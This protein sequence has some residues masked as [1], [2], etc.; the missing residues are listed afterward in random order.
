[1][2]NVTKTGAT[3][4]PKIKVEVVPKGEYKPGPKIKMPPG[5]T[6]IFAKHQALGGDTGLLGKATGPEQMTPNGQGWYRHY[7]H[8]SIYWTSAAGAFEVH[9]DIRAKWE[10][11]GWETSFL[12]FPITDETTTPDGVGR[13]NHFQG[14]SIYWTPATGAHEVHGDIR[15]KWSALGWERSY[16]GYPMSDEQTTPDGI[17]RYSDFEHGQITWSPALGA[18]VSFTSYD[19]AAGGGG[20]V[21]PQG[22][23][24]NGEPEVRRRLVCSAHMDLTDD[25]SWPWHDEHSSADGTNEAVLTTDLPQDV[26]TM[27]DGAGGELRV[28]LKLIAQVRSNGDVLVKG[29]L[30]LFEGTSE[31]NNDLDGNETF[32]ILVPRDGITSEQV[33]V[34]NED[35]GGDLAVVSMNFSNYAI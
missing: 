22:L 26:L 14:G 17:G 7:Q 27:S 5:V 28:E 32:N 21:K 29:N 30:D 23:P 16:L 11:L 4:K 25:E 13:F 24:G 6:A 10:T 34:R 18:A 12:G 19:P 33:T 3:Q 20:G 1:M 9:G 35:E 31:Q 2:T 15:T 8:G